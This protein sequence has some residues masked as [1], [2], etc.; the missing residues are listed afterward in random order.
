MHF[1]SFNLFYFLITV[2][3]VLI[4]LPI[5]SKLSKAEKYL[6][7]IIILSF[8]LFLVRF[9]LIFFQKTIGVMPYLIEDVVFYTLLLIF[10]ILFTLVYVVKI[11]KVSF[12]D[13]GGNLKKIKKSV[14]YGLIAYL[15]LLFLLPLV[16]LLTDIQVSF[17]IT[18]G[19]IIVAISFSILGAFYEE[20]MFRG[21]IQNH[22][23]RMTNNNGKISIFFTAL[24]FTATHLFYLPFYGFCIFYIYVFIMALILSILR[25]KLDLLACAILHGGIV[26]ILI[27]LV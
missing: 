7:I 22:L 17:K 10:G 4:L 12:K 3:I 15:P 11:E 18:I 25:F 5:I 6:P 26:F 2:P 21:V 13:I 23:M 16:L 14:F 24:I 20:I 27:V 1:Y 9:F 8:L 19:K